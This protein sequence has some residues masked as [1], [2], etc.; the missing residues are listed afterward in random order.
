MYH[1]PLILE[2]HYAKQQKTKQ[3][4]NESNFSKSSKDITP[5]V[6]GKARRFSAAFKKSLGCY[7]S[8]PNLALKQRS[9]A[10]SFKQGQ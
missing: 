7:S 4:S 10:V 8:L 6:Q 3:R 9:A 5:P 2:D 1:E